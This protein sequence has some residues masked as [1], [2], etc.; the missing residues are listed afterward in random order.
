MKNKTLLP[1]VAIAFSVASSVS[2]AAETVNIGVPS[3]TGAQAIANLLKVVV[4][5]RIGG[6]ADLVPIA[7]AQAIKR[8]LWMAARLWLPHLVAPKMPAKALDPPG[9]ASQGNAVK[10]L[11]Q[12]GFHP[13]LSG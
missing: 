9:H 12:T 4:E 5:T 2:Y 10:G 8:A 13:I 1:I 7:N 11:F 3:W 6:T